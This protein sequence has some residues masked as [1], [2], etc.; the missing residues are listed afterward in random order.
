MPHMH[1]NFHKTESYIDL[2]ILVRIASAHEKPRSFAPEKGGIIGG[3]EGM[4]VDLDKG[5]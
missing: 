5:N 3:R 1:E 2:M 4:K